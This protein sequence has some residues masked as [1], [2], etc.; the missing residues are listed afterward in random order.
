M[1]TLFDNQNELLQYCRKNLEEFRICRNR[2]FDL[3]KRLVKART[4]QEKSNCR[5]RTLLRICQ[6]DFRTITLPK[7]IIIYGIGNVGKTFYKNIKNKCQIKYFVETYPQE[8]VYE[9][10]PII[11]LDEIEPC[12]DAIFVVSAMYDYERIR[13]SIEER[14]INA[15][16][17]PLDAVLE[18]C[19]PKSFPDNTYK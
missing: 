3:E 13:C 1:S 4:E 11:S 16:V 17:F 5:Y 7:D 15:K 2:I 18:E 6:S 9:D 8:K 14:V 19:L 10:I 12:E